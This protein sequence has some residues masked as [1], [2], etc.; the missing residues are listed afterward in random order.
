ML[1]YND[2]KEGTI[3][4]YEGAPY[5]VIHFAFLRMQQRKPVAQTEIKNLITGKVLQRNFQMSDS[6]E[7]AEINKV[8]V[9]YL[10]N[11]RGEY[12]FTDIKDASKRFALKEDVIGTAGAFSK[13]N[14]ETT[15]VKWGER[16]ISVI[17]PIKAELKIKETAPGERGD[18]ARAGTKAA[19]VETGAT[20]LVPLFVNTGDLIRINTQTGEYVERVEK[21]ATGL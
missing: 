19:I 2:L 16:I 8:P 11:H 3:F 4:V 5:E 21:A 9:K 17:F 15:A 1:S 7:E 6:F 14:T 18:T 10:Y 20:I 12:W 13:P